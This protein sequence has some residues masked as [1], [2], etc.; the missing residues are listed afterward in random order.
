MLAC[1]SRLTTWPCH[2]AFNNWH[3]GL[4]RAWRCQ[5]QLA[6]E[7]RSNPDHRAR[8]DDLVPNIRSSAL[9]AAPGNMTC[10]AWIPHCRGDLRMAGSVLDVHNR[11]AG[12]RLVRQRRMSGI[13]QWP[14]ATSRPALADDSCPGEGPAGSSP[15]TSCSH[16]MAYRARGGRRRDLRAAEFG[17]Q[18]GEATLRHPAEQLVRLATCPDSTRRLRGR[19]GDPLQ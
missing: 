19:R 14:K 12:C 3:Q 1:G 6:N 18:G 7:C 2:A 17:A 15:E 9:R 4:H 11:V 13:L 5:S 10:A 16:R 8:R